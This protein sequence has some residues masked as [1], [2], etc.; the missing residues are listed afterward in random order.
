MSESV[1]T[2]LPVGQLADLVNETDR[3]VLQA[4]L[5]EERHT[6]P[7][8]ATAANGTLGLSREYLNTRLAHLETFGF[9]ER[10]DRGLY[11]IDDNGRALADGAGVGV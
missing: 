9:V 5:D 8:L 7:D 6:A 11:R 3:R 2:G 10:V 1:A 4:M